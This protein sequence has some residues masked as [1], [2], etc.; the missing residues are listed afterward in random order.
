[1]LS[2]VSFSHVRSMHSYTDCRIS[3]GSSST[4]LNDKDKESR[5]MF[6]NRVQEAYRI[7]FTH[8]SLG[9][10]CLIST[11]WWLRSSAV[12]ELNTF[13]ERRRKE[14]AA[15]D[16]QEG[17]IMTGNEHTGGNSLKKRAMKSSVGVYLPFFCTQQS[18][19]P[20]HD[21]VIAAKNTSCTCR[22][23]FIKLSKFVLQLRGYKIRLIC[24]EK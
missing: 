21:T 5:N 6:L 20:S 23:V 17:E 14:K 13:E 1:M 11:W 3:L 22:V 19:S 24:T 9:K 16:Q 2:W 4:H 8:P 12:L 7:F 15:S 18:V 10:L